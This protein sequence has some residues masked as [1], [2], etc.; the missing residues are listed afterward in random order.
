MRRRRSFVA[1]LTSALV[2]SSIMVIGVSGI[3]DAASRS[4]LAGTKPSWATAQHL[5]RRRPQLG[6]VD[7]VG[8]HRQRRGPGTLARKEA[9]KDPRETRIGSRRV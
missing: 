7:L 3:T 8:V 4:T 5:V 6:V 1:T 9:D 2:L